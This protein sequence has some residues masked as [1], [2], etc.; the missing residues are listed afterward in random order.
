M[1]YIDRRESSE[2]LDNGIDIKTKGPKGELSVTIDS[3]IKIKPSNQ[4]I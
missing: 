3:I 2:L 4:N 1:L